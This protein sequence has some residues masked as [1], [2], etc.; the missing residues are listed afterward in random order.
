M[1]RI[2]ITYQKIN[3]KNAKCDDCFD[4]LAQ[5][6]EEINGRVTEKSQYKCGECKKRDEQSRAAVSR[7]LQ[8]VDQFLKDVLGSLSYN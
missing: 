3:N 5:Y 2:Q 7:H 4:S 1:T 6:V 8:V